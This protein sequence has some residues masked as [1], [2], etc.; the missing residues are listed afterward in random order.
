MADDIQASSVEEALEAVESRRDLL[1]G[2]HPDTLEAMSLLAH[3][4]R[5]AG[6]DQSARE[7]LEGVL[8]VRT[9]ILGADHIDTLRTEFE[10]GLVLKGLNDLFSAR[11]IQEQLL[12]SSDRQYGPDSELSVRA[13]AN[14]ANTL[15]SMKRYDLELPLRERVVETRRASVGPQHLD[16]FRALVDLASVNHNLHN[17]KLALDLNL[18][19]LEGFEQNAVDRRAVLALQFNIVIDLIRLKRAREAAE[20]FERAY[21]EVVVLLPPDDPLRVQAEKQRRSMTFLGKHARR[22]SERRRRKLDREN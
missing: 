16:F 2:D 1:G 20:V 12:E 9:R 18:I 22:L 3:A 17:R 14:L 13:A 19:V 15:R 8:A 7:Q 21:N 4:Y 5:D 10:L 11:R 6:D